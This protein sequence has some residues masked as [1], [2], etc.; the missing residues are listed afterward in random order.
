MLI[1]LLFLLDY[2]FQVLAS[3]CSVWKWDVEL[4]DQASADGLIQIVRSI[5]RT[6]YQNSSF[7]SSERVCTIELDQKFGL[8]PSGTFLVVVVSGTKQTVYLIDEH[9]ARLVD[10]RD[11]KHG[12]DHFL[13][14]SDPL[15][16]QCRCRDTQ[17][18][19]F[20]LGCD[21]L[22]EQS[23][24]SAW[25][26]EQHDPSGWRTHS[27]ED[28]G[29]LHG[30]NYDFIDRLFRELKTRNIVPAQIWLLLHNFTLNGFNHARIQ[31]FVPLIFHPCGLVLL[32][33]FATAATVRLFRVL[34]QHVLSD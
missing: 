6:N 8:Y 31:I 21:R 27:S 1:S 24:P 12:P 11:S 26:S 5:R 25:R 10:R 30:P 17:E 3:A 32:I 19:C 18:S 9:H 22:A 4:L 33:V 23:L 15:R 2:S 20:T 29:A 16:G 7:I 14:F 34:I 28:I 13:T